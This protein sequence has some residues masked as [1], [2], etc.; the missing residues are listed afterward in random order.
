MD[1]SVLYKLIESEVS[2]AYIFDLDILKERMNKIKNVLGE[3]YSLCYAM[4]ANPFLVDA[5][6]GLA[7][8]YEVCSPGEFAICERE[9]IPMERIVLSGV[10]K[11]EADI[12]YI[13]EHNLE[14]G[15]FTVESMQQFLLLYSC[16]KKY[17]KAIHVLLRI[18]SGNQFG[19]DKELAE[20]LIERKD[21]YACLHIKGFQYYSGTQK[22]KIEKIEKEIDELEAFCEK[23][24][25]TY[26]YRTE[27]L[28]YGPGLFVSYFEPDV[29]EEED[30][31]PLVRLKERLDKLQGKYRIT[32]EMGR[33]FTAECGTFLTKMVDLKQN[34]GQNYCIV[35][36]GIHH[37]NY[38]GQTMAMKLPAIAHIKKTEKGIAWDDRQ[39]LSQ[40]E[41]TWI[42]CGSLCTVGDVLVKNLKLHNAEC[43][44]YLVFGN[45]GAYSVT[46]GIYLFLS[47][48]LPNV[49]TYDKRNGLILMRD[50]FPTDWINSRKVLDL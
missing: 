7:D 46:E 10:N 36:G 42:V 39:N 47:R 12:A 45:L 50:N 5:M 23:M 6:K 3:D 29:R 31:T 33:Y 11:E 28:E 49:Y 26:G 44:D 18:T 20:W 22:K 1:N 19:M 38:Y 34:G 37:I 41:K 25:H 16:A 27:E 4:K 15:M 43:G 32:L 48:R 24:E 14:V 21:Q 2:P 8:K 35:D 40:E 9:Q 30:I 17:G 13:M